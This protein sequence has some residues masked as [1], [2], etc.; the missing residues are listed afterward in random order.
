M[1]ASED[2]SEKPPRLK[3]W[4]EAYDGATPWDI[5]R[6][7]PE[8]MRLGADGEV[9]GD[10]L[11][12]G[13]GTG[14]NAI[15]FASL[16]FRVFGVDIAPKAVAR[17]LAKAKDRGV[18][19]EFAVADALDLGK[20]G[21]RFDAIL[22]SSLFHTFDDEERTPFARSLAAAAKPGGRYHMLC[23]SEHEPAGWGPR[24]VTQAEIRATFSEGWIVER[25]RPASIETSHEGR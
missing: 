13:C 3:T 15:H 4:D 12:V 19:A 14:D 24:R 16:G 9:V 23:F 11:D 10:V 17:A 8:L 5:G 20:L 6:P 7:Q 22:D 1:A 18:D 2:D 25:I 21:R